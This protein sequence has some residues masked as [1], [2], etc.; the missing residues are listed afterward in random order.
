MAHLLTRVP[1]EARDVPTVE[2]PERQEDQGYV[3]PPRDAY[4]YVPDHAASL[5]TKP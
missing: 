4:T 2:L 5:P 3:R 1:Y